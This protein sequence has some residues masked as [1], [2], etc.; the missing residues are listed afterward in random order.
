MKLNPLTQANK[1]DGTNHGPPTE[2]AAISREHG[3]KKT[4]PMAS[5]AEM[6]LAQANEGGG[7]T[8]KKHGVPPTERDVL[9]IAGPQ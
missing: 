6:P 7:K 4:S 8:A 1:G 5:A 9:L 2:G 3:V